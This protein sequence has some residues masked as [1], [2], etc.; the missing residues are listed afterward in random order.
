MHVTIIAHGNGLA[1]FRR[2]KPLW[3]AHDAATLVVVPE[4]DP[5]DQ[6]ESPWPVIHVAKAQH[7]G[8]ESKI[9][10]QW[11]LEYLASLELP[12]YVIYEYDSFCLSPKIHLQRGFAGNVK[13]NKYPER[14]LAPRYANPPWVLDYGSLVAMLKASRRWPDLVEEGEADRYLSALAWLGNVPVL[15]HAP[16]GYSDGCITE[17]EITYLRKA[18]YGGSTMIHGIKQEWTWRAALQFYD[19]KPRV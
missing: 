17:Y 19:E 4:D 3:A 16:P 11:I 1:A 15:P 12:R 13:A 7:N 5:I 10:L 8:P 9:R 14:F 6:S 18:I 2:H